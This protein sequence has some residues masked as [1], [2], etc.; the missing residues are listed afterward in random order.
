MN[1]KTTTTSLVQKFKAIH[2]NAFD[3]SKVNYKYKDSSVLIGCPKHGFIKMNIRSHK[4]KGCTVCHAKP[5]KKR[6][7]K[8]FIKIATKLHNG[9]YTYDNLNYTSS[10]NSVTI[11]CPVHGDFSQ[12]VS[13]H[14]RGYRC[15][16]CTRDARKDTTKTFITKAKGIHRTTYDYSEVYYRHSQLP[17]KIK[18]FKHGTF[19]QTPNNHLNGQGCPEC[20]RHAK[21]Y[22]DRPST[23]K[24]KTMLLG[25]TQI[26]VQ[27]YED[28]A[29]HYLIKEEGIKPSHILVGEAVPKIRYKASAL[30]TNSYFKDRLYF[31]DLYIPKYNL[32][33][34][35]KSIFTFLSGFDNLKEKRQATVEKGYRFEIMIMT[36]EGAYIRPPEYWYLALKCDVKKYLK[37]NDA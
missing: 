7:A 28:L 8:Q 17:V 35:V 5:R 31:P 34:E 25:N 26:T 20:S 30:T 16:K 9:F 19:K 23:Y 4:N 6:T 21:V 15:K 14:L 29:I 32:V 12:L 27:G 3:Y 10:N 33:I 11:T 36:K 1:L 18:C 13:G 24:R 22:A 37:T 2:G